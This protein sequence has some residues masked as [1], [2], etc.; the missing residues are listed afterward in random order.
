MNEL[1][2][3]FEPKRT[4]LKEYLKYLI[5]QVE[6]LKKEQDKQSKDIHELKMDMEKRNTIY[7]ERQKQLRG[8]WAIVGIIG[9]VVGFL[10]DLLI[11]NFGK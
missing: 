5:E 9:G 10:I 4:T 2:E 1:D 8:V 3:P 6:E 11:K 7:E